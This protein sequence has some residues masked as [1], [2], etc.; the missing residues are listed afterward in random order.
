MK[1]N[2]YAHTTRGDARAMPTTLW[3]AC[4]ARHLDAYYRPASLDVLDGL[5]AAR[6]ALS[7]ALEDYLRHDPREEALARRCRIVWPFRH[8][9][10]LDSLKPRLEV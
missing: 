5:D 6:F 8:A 9:I 3:L 10:A 4:I 1:L 7:L 2:S